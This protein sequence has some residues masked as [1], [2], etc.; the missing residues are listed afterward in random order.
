MKP[1]FSTVACPDW[2]FE[3]IATAA[4][5]GGWQGVELRSFGFGGTRLAC[6]PSQT[7]GEKVRALFSAAGTEVSCIATS[8]C[9]DAPI[10]PA[11]IGALSSKPGLPL[12]HVHSALRIA[13]SLDCNL[14]RVFGAQVQAGQTRQ[15]TIHRIASQLAEAGD[16]A[17][18]TGARVA[19]ENAG[20][21][22]TAADVCE[23]L[24]LVDHPHVGV[25]YCPALAKLTGEDPVAGLNVIGE[26]L[27]S[28]KLRDYR[29]GVPCHL[30]D[31]EL[32]ARAVVDAL[33]K[34]DFRG[35]L[36]FEHDR[37]WNRDASEPA[38][39]LA[40]AARRLYEWIGGST[41]TRG[42]RQLV[43]V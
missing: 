17:K 39:T 36:V 40:A 12:R 21:F 22:T 30:G 9:F 34:A 43:E 37:L 38:A 8:A 32:P 5:E 28:V 24:D 27:M 29:G 1:A 31:G 42:T 33:G 6:E 18:N 25:A 16:M 2:T 26:R 14:I 4:E 13:M 20:S 3:R 7:A 41:H 10:R 19:L 23:I 35:W 11:I 15:A